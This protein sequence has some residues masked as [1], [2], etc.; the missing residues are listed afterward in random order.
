MDVNDPIEDYLS[1]MMQ[2]T[3]IASKQGADKKGK[4]SKRQKV[5]KMIEDKVETLKKP[6]ESKNARRKRERK[7]LHKS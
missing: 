2:V 5:D 4:P 1:D 6:K 3:I 7:D